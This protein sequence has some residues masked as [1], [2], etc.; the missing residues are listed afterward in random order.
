MLCR[1]CKEAGK[2]AKACARAYAL[3]L[4]LILKFKFIIGLPQSSSAD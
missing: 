2:E 3:R 4:R 1:A